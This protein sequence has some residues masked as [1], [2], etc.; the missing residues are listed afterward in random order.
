MPRPDRSRTTKH[1][2]ASDDHALTHSMA[3]LDFDLPLTVEGEPLA[4]ATTWLLT[5]SEPLDALD[6]LDALPPLLHSTDNSQWHGALPSTSHH[7]HNSSPVPVAASKPRRRNTKPPSQPRTTARHQETDKARRA[8]LKQETYRLRQLIQQAHATGLHSDSTEQPADVDKLDVAG[9][10]GRGAALIE[11]MTATLQQLQAQLAAARSTSAVTSS[12]QTAAARRAMLTAT[13]IPQHIG[14]EHHLEAMGVIVKRTTL[15]FQVLSVNSVYQTLTG[16]HWS[17]LVGQTLELICQDSTNKLVLPTPQ[18]VQAFTVQCQRRSL[19]TVPESSQTLCAT[20]RVAPFQCD[21]IPITGAAQVQPLVGSMYTDNT[22]IQ[23]FT[24]QSTFNG[25][26]M[27]SVTRMSL[28]RNSAG[29]PQHFAMISAP[30]ERRKV[31]LPPPVAMATQP[32][33]RLDSYDSNSHTI[34]IELLTPSL[35]SSASS[36]TAELSDA[37]SPS[38]PATSPSINFESPLPDIDQWLPISPTYSWPINAA[39]E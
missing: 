6:A 39:L 10:V 33:A 22:T 9:V 13:T 17:A 16:Y 19:D 7:N 34:A 5:S 21:G 24:T 18:A 28:V 36:E 31:A 25:D 35:A 3:E 20:H 12:S 30:T 23:I 1:W 8:R 27:E 2:T 32:N 15:D 29:T 4:D 38:Y 14:F 11:A 37:V 26:L